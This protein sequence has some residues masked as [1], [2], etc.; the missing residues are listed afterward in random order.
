MHIPDIGWTEGTKAE[1]GVMSD[2]STAV[3]IFIVSRDVGI[4]IENGFLELV[5]LEMDQEVKSL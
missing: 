5:R 4:E 1:D 3:G 2:K